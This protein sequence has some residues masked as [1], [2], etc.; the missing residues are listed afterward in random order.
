MQGS[1]SRFQGTAMLADTTQLFGD[2]DD[3]GPSPPETY[4][5]PE[6]T[7]PMV[8]DGSLRIVLVDEG[9]AS[10]D[11]ET[12]TASY[13]RE[14]YFHFCLALVPPQGA[15][16]DEK[17]LRSLVREI[18]EFEPDLVIA[19]SNGAPALLTLIARSFWRGPT[20]LL[21]PL[22]IPGVDDAICRLRGDMPALQRWVDSLGFEHRGQE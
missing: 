6:R 13:L 1:S 19:R 15:S 3:D 2:S 5:M 18:H 8:R 9:H 10:G 17:L 14:H 16:E 12:R 21:C 22:V 20:V 11:T 7:V 4:R